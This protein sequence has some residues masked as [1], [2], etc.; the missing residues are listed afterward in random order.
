M[1]TGFNI[2]GQTD[3]GLKREKNEDNFAFDANIGLMIVSDGMGGHASG[4]VASSLATSA[5]MEQMK[6]ALDTG[7][8]PVYSHVNG[9]N[10]DKRSVL[11]GDSIKFSNQAVYEASR[12]NPANH[13]MGTTMVAALMLGKKLAIAHVG[14]SRL[15]LIRQSDIIQCTVDHSFIQEQV[16]RGLL[17]PD[18]AEKS[19]LK[20]MLTRSV[21]VDSDVKVDVREIDLQSGDYIL[22]C[23]DGLTKMLSDDKILTPFI[24]DR[25]PQD[26]TNDLIKMA[27][28]A[29]GQDN[30][31]VIVAK[32]PSHWG[33]LKT[34]GSKMKGLFDRKEK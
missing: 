19:E 5:A 14:D 32:V 24:D 17:N 31:T 8:V 13:N 12:S 18:E 26:I 28:E 4:D 16:D 34:I 20:N 9:A 30:I 33:S 7:R 2:S 29:G 15:Y 3:P 27:N 6:L 11:L 1:A 22:I 23:S 10:L 25:E 21:G